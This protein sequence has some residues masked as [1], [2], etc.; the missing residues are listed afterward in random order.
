MRGGDMLC[1]LTSMDEVAG[2]RVTGEWARLVFVPCV[3]FIRSSIQSHAQ[4][5]TAFCIPSR[6]L[7]SGCFNT[8]CPTP[9][10]GM[11]CCAAVTKA[12]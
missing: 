10:V 1:K 9:L 5:Q 3:L 7:E 2:K 12:K 6:G 8:L 11:G 4:L